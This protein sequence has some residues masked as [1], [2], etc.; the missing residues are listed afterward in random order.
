MNSG[1]KKETST[2]EN[3][4]RGEAGGELRE[5]RVWG[6]FPGMRS[7]AHIFSYWEIAASSLGLE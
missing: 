6:R 1:A 4:G 3:S 7:G 2:S 5:K